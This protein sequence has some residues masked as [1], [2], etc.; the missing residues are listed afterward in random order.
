[1]KTFPNARNPEIYIAVLRGIGGLRISEDGNTQ[2]KTALQYAK[3]FKREAII[4]WFAR[5]CEEVLYFFLCVCV[6]VCVC[7]YDIYI[8]KYIYVYMCMYTYTFMYIYIHMYVYKYT[9][10]HLCV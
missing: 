9:H 5:G 3:E 10:I 1:M 2:G 6:Y 8:Y 4:Q 7:V